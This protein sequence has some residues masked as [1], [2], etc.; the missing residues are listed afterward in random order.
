MPAKMFDKRRNVCCCARSSTIYCTIHFDSTHVESLLLAYLDQMRGLADAAQGYA[1]AN[2]LAL[3]KLLQGHLRRVDLSHLSL[4]S[5]Y[6][7]GIEMQDASLAGAKLQDS[8]F[9]TPFDTI[10]AV[11]IS[12]SGNYWAGSCRGGEVWLWE[13]HGLTLKRVWIAHADTLPAMAFSP[14]ERFLATCGGWD[15]TLKLWEVATG[16]LLW[17][18]RHT[19]RVNG[20]AFSPGGDQVVTSSNDATLRIWDTLSSVQLQIIAHPN[21]ASS[22]AWSQDGQ[23]LASG[24][25]DGNI[26]L[27]AILSSGVATRVQTFAGHTVVVEGLAFSPDGRIL[28]TAGWEHEVKL[29]EVS[30][31]RLLQK[32]AGPT[33]GVSRVAWSSRWPGSGQCLPGQNHLAVGG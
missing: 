29:W 32:L 25:I 8:S 10:K 6:L 18:G 1:P 15:S 14:D 26:H 28:A 13:A 17:T 12:S 9:T 24:G 5:V 2:L 22:V 33:E 19:S 16:R 4:R 31:G 7:Q 3:L 20:V 21:Q 27:W 11:A 23:L 30:S